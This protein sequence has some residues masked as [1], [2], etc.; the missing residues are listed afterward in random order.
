MEIKLIIQLGLLQPLMLVLV[1]EVLVEESLGTIH[2]LREH[3]LKLFDPLLNL[4]LQNPTP[5]PCGLLWPQTT[6]GTREVD[7]S[8]GHPP[9]DYRVK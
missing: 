2:I 3:I 9:I 4:Q 8:G 1:L 5:S 6:V 7:V